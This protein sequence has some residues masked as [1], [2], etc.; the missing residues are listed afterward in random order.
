MSQKNLIPPKLYTAALEDVFKLLNWKRLGININGKYITY[1][2]FAD[3]ILGSRGITRYRPLLTCG[4][5]WLRP[6]SS[7]GRPRV[8][9]NDDDEYSLFKAMN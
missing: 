9:D 5:L 8:D 6:M 4:A 1:F 2:R 3:D 7:S